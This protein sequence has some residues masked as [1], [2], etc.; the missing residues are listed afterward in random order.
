MAHITTKR[1][2]V[3]E[4]KAGEQRKD[5]LVGFMGRDLVEK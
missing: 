3:V 2:T 4:S 1:L 5:I